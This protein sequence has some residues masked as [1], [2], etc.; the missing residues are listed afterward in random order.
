MLGVAIVL[1]MVAQLLMYGKLVW[2]LVVETGKPQNKAK[3]RQIRK[4]T[5]SQKSAEGSIDTQ[6]VEG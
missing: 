4:P 3:E 2:W 6:K 5:L 1:G